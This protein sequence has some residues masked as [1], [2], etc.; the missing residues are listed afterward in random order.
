[1]NLS[2]DSTGTVMTFTYKM[3]P[4][5]KT[6]SVNTTY[7]CT[8]GTGAAGTGFVGTDPELF[9]IRTAIF[10]D[11]GERIFKYRRP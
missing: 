7:L 6:W 9:E 8:V 4:S 1:M 11:F 5:H 2:G 10:S 3:P